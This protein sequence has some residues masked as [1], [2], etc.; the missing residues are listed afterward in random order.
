ML[1]AK[2]RR[3]VAVFSHMGRIHEFCGK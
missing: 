2:R 3:P 1:I